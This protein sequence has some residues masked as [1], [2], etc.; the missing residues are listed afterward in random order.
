MSFTKRKLIYIFV[1]STLS[2]QNTDSMPNGPGISLIIP[3]SNLENT[4]NFV[5]P[6]KFEPFQD[7][8][9]PFEDKGNYNLSQTF[10]FLVKIA[11]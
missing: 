10:S 7:T 9:Y 11:K 2:E 5:S 1:I 3:A 6:E 8:L 4:W